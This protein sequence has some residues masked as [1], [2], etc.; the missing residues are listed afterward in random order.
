MVAYVGAL[1]IIFGVML[2]AIDRDAGMSS[3][4]TAWEGPGG[5]EDEP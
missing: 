4:W 2:I 3:G 5:G 1:N